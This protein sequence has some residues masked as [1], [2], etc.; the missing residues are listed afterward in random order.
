MCIIDKL[1]WM[2][3]KNK[4]IKKKVL[5]MQNGKN[6]AHTDVDALRPY[7]K[8]SSLSHNTYPLFEY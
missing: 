4:C 8:I 5:N 7:Q 6:F 3:C 1:M 2:F